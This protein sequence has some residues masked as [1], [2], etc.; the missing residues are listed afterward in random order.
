MCFRFLQ[1]A[2]TPGA[3]VIS[4]GT[5]GGVARHVGNALQG[6]TNAFIGVCPWGVI[7]ERDALRGEK[8]FSIIK[9]ERDFSIFKLISV[10]GVRD[11]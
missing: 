11:F 1:I 2:Q 4:G 7:A 9:H 3:W 10:L 8:R 5:N 6:C